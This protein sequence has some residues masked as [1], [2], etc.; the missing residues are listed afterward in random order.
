MDEEQKKK[1]LEELQKSVTEAVAPLV[2]KAAVEAATKAVGDM[3]ALVQ[4]NKSEDKLEKEKQEKGVEYFKGVVTRDGARIR[5]HSKAGEPLNEGTSTEGQEWAPEYFEG[6]IIEI[7]P[8]YGLVRQKATKVPLPGRKVTWP[9][10]GEIDAFK[11]DE[12]AAIKARKPASGSFVMEPEKLGVLIPVSKELLE[13]NNLTLGLINYLNLVAARAFA[14]LEDAMGLGLT[15]SSAGEGVFKKSGVPQKVI[16][17]TEFTDV[18]FEE[19]LEGTELLDDDLE[20]NI[21]WVMSRSMRNI[22]LAKRFEVDSD[23]QEFIFGN[24]GGGQPRTLWDYPMTL[25]RSM[26]KRADSDPEELFMSLVSWDNVMFGDRRQ[27]RIELSDVATIKGTDDDTLI[28]AFM[29][30]AVILKYT[31]RIDVELANHTKAFVRFKT[32]ASGS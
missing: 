10:G 19:L 5:K 3:P 18:T 20:G 8:K 1:A 26:P 4:L 16:A 29:Q 23:K 7:A 21:D 6:K 25:H 28:H 24:P 15:G 22:L 14:K 11:V 17:G 2:T 32:A 31:E 13:D 12:L 30:D 27:Y 9:T